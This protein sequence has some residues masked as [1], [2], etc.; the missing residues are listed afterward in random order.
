LS[1][2]GVTEIV[3]AVGYHPVEME[4]YLRKYEE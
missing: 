2:A 1:K 3:L 4:V